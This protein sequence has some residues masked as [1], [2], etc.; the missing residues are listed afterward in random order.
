MKRRV[1]KQQ[2]SDQSIRPGL[3]VAAVGTLAVTVVL[4]WALKSTP[5]PT[6]VTVESAAPVGPPATAEPAATRTRIRQAVATPV[7]VNTERLRW[8]RATRLSMPEMGT[9]TTAPGTA[10][11]LAGFQGT[12]TFDYQAQAAQVAGVVR[13]GIAQAERRG[14]A[15]LPGSATG[16]DPSQ[17]AGGLV[18]QAQSGP[19]GSVPNEV[20]QPERGGAA[21]PPGSAAQVS[22]GSGPPGAQAGNNVVEAYREGERLRRA[23]VEEMRVRRIA[24]IADA[25]Q[26]EGM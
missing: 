23:Y 9:D 26:R 11:S 14:D 4:A 6:G 20:T 5:S 18:Y 15:T 25:R 12:G 16:F 8:T 1:I 21:T 10:T 19:V 2:S 17:G 24:T 13:S 3:L 22:Q 7:A